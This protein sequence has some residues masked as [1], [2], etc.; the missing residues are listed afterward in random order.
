MGTH[1]HT[2][3]HT[4]I[5]TYLFVVFPVAC[6][7]LDCCIQTFLNLTPQLHTQHTSSKYLSGAAYRTRMGVLQC[8]ST[9][10]IDMRV[11]IQE[12]YYYMRVCIC[13]ITTVLLLYASVEMCHYKSAI[14]MI[15]CY[16]ATPKVSYQVSCAD[17]L[18]YS[19]ATDLLAPQS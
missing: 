7:L 6:V 3:T 11:S 5:H 1:T 18:G 15:A 16:V 9:S 4:H 17:L 12:C 13:V 8:G 10:A 14:A 19:R 2:H